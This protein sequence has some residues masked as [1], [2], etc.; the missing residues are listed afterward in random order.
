MMILQKDR[1]TS[2]HL[3]LKRVKYDFYIGGDI[4][5]AEQV[6]SFDLDE[7]IV[8]ESY[9]KAL[10]PQMPFDRFVATEEDGKYKLVKKQ[11]PA[12]DI[13]EEARREENLMEEI[14]YEDKGYK[15]KDLADGKCSVEDSCRPVY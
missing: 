5:E 3:F 2:Q 6:Y 4:R 8:L 1:G 10:L 15:L 13:D 9:E 11:V 7:D 12:S 14:P